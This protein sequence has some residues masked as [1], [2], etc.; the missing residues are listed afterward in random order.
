MD[1]LLMNRVRAGAGAAWWVVIILMASMMF[2]YAVFLVIIQTKPD[3]M[4]ALWGGS[5][6]EGHVGWHEIHYMSLVLYGA[7]KVLLFLFVGT[8]LWLTIWARKL[9]K[10]A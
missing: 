2:S 7:F 3:W 8:A 10:A 5:K 6:L 4:L 9:R 1:D